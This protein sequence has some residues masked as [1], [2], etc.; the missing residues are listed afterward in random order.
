MSDQ[1]FNRRVRVTCWRETAPSDPTLFNP[2]KIGEALVITDL[3]VQFK[4][5]RSLKKTPNAC[6][7]T[8]TNLSEHARADL[9]TKPLFVQLDAGYNDSGV[10]LL[11]TGDLRFGMSEQKGPEWETLLQL[12]DGDCHHQWSRTKRAYAAGTTVRTVLRDLAKSFGFPLPTSLD[13]DARLD[14]PY[15]TGTTTYGLTQAELARVLLPFGYYHSIQNGA[16]QILRT[17]DV[18]GTVP[19]VLDQAHGMIGSPT[20]GSPP[21]SGKPPHMNVKML[22]YPEIGAGQ[23]VQVISR[24][25]TGLFKAD[26]VVH[27]GDTHGSEWYSE[28]EIVPYTSADDNPKDAS[29][30]DGP[31]KP[32]VQAAAGAVAAGLAVASGAAGTALGGSGIRG[33]TGR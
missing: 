16:L 27:K 17:G 13:A 22:L 26:K 7:V 10:R 1:L 5:E 32:A 24:A 6:D 12:G 14:Q 18:S 15:P 29:G 3:R 19:L 21:K 9:T 4:V 31:A 25:K 28:V 23:L 2:L 33:A 11:Y 20:F 30:D 8:I